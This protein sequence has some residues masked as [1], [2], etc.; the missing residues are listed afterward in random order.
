M[1]RRVHTMRQH[2][3]AR[4]AARRGFTLVEIMMVVMLAGAL[5]VVSVP[6]ITTF[7]ARAELR[8]AKDHV[9]SSLAAELLLAI[10]R[11]EITVRLQ[12]QPVDLDGDASEEA[13]AEAAAGRV[14]GWREETREAAGMTS[15]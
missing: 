9:A 11:E 8:A 10:D 4:S 6:K 12:L 14:S 2:F 7:V 13:L 3:P 15:R 1:P 5:M